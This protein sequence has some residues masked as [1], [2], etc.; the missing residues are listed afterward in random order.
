METH[1]EADQDKLLL[2]KLQN[3]GAGMRRWLRFVGV[4]FILMAL[5]YAATGYGLLIAWIPA[6]LGVILFQA[7]G[8]AGRDGGEHLVGFLDRLRLFFLVFSV[9][10]IVVF[11]FSFLILVFGSG[12]IILR[13]E[14]SGLL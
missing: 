2:R 10:L 3:T 4:G 6:W 5:P 14:E 13:L 9:L 1:S 12:A 7:A 8:R 11:V